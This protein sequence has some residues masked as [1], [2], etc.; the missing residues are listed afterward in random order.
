M[1]VN[2]DVLSTGIDL[3]FVSC[4]VDCSPTKSEIRHVQRLGRGLRRAEGKTDLI[5]LDHSGNH[6]RLGRVDDIGHS[7]LDDG[8]Q[9]NKSNKKTEEH[10]TPLARLCDACKAI[11]P[12]RSIV[13]SECGHE[14]EARS[15]I[16]HIDGELVEL[17]SGQA[18]AKRGQTIE[19]KAA[20]YA[21][22]LGYAREHGY[23]EGWASYKYRERFGVWPND[24]RVRCAKPIAAGLKT[25][26]WIRSRAIAFAKGHPHAA[27]GMR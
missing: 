19:D 6:L 25:R 21:E 11:L 15:T 22:L 24:P 26:N 23:R 5:V 16:V 18:P 1:L 2:V 9:R 14:R 3:P 13:C 17:G 7:R 4:I 12:A 10:K 20:F 8:R 27:G